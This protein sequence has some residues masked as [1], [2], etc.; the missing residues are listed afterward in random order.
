MAGLDFETTVKLVYKDDDGNMDTIKDSVMIKNEINKYFP[1]HLSDFFLFDGENLIKFQNNTSSDFIKNGITK[2]SGL[3]ILDHLSRSALQT[4]KEI[5][6]QMGGKSAEAAPYEASVNKITQDKTDLESIIEKHEKKLDEAKMMY[7][8]ITKKITQNKSGADLKKRL[9]ETRTNR[10][11]ALI[12]RKKNNETMKDMLFEKI[13]QILLRDTLQKSEDIFARLEDEDKIP[14]SISRGALDKILG[15]VP[16]RCMCG[17][18]FEK[19]D[20]PNSP[21]ITL[22]RIK[23]TIIEDGLSQG[24][25]LGRDLISRIIDVGSIEKSRKEYDERVSIRRDKNKEI[26]E[27]DAGMD[28]LENQISEISYDYDQ[29]LGKRHI[30]Q[31]GEMMHHNSEITMK[32]QDL[33]DLNIR[34]REATTKRDAALEKEGKI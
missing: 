7:G 33:D 9:D 16:L 24:I 1:Q 13:P 17:R 8:E 23:D 5:G 2:I 22:N 6:R 20:E 25:S 19:N 26:Q 29:D 10:K 28:D 34:L 15:T 4:A 27:Y 18:E 3:G 21:W 30:E 14:P 12:D 11:S 31:W 32:K